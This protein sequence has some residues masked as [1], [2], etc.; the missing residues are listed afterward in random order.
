MGRSSRRHR[1]VYRKL[2]HETYLQSQRAYIIRSMLS[3][4]YDPCYEMKIISYPAMTQLS[5]IPTL[6]EYT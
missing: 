6:G 5:E 2:S 3:G 4:S 1:S